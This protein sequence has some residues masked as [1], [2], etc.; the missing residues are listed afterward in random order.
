LFSKNLRSPSS[1]CSLP[2]SSEISSLNKAMSLSPMTPLMTNI[3]IKSIE[4]LHYANN[5][6]FHMFPC[7]IVWGFCIGTFSRTIVAKR[8][9]E[10]WCTS[11]QNI[12]FMKSS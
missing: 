6:V 7:I 11:S 4:A 5:L 9:I 3:I 8:C 10:T 12:L 1:T 2:V